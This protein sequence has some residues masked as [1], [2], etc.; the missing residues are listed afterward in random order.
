[1]QAAN[2][3]SGERNQEVDRIVV[4]LF[5]VQRASATATAAAAAGAKTN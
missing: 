5:N 1:M 4:G 3:L 2:E